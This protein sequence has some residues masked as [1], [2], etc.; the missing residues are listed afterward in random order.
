MIIDCGSLK[1]LEKVNAIDTLNLPALK[2]VYIG[3]TLKGTLRQNNYDNPD[4]YY[5]PTIIFS[6]ENLSN[7]TIGPKVK[8]LS[9]RTF[10]EC[11]NLTN[12]TI[13]DGNEILTFT[14]STYTEEIDDS[15][16]KANANIHIGRPFA[17]QYYYHGDW[18]TRS[19]NIECGDT[20]SL[21]RSVTQINAHIE[22]ENLKDIYCM[23]AIPPTLWRGEETFDNTVYLNATLHVPTGSLANYQA[24]DY[25]KAFF[26]IQEEEDFPNSVP[27]VEDKT[28]PCI[29]MENGNVI[30]EN[31]R[32]MITVYDLSGAVVKHLQAQN[33]RVEMSLPKH[34]VYIVKAGNKTEKVVL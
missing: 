29:K 1:A 13:L 8:S 15:F 14:D 19:L 11:N 20:L 33:G 22:G 21:G 2:E 12:I 5:H 34:R 7:A 6:C 32:D 24:A 9:T 4:I 10:N 30:V 26:L 25:W 3:R 27:L 16:G 28:Q 31:A 17:F 18:S 23:S